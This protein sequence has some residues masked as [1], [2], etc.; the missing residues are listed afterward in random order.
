MNFRLG[1]VVNVYGLLNYDIDFGLSDRELEHYGLSDVEYTHYD[2]EEGDGDL[3][4]GKSHRARLKGITIVQNK[5]KSNKLKK[6]TLFDINRFLDRTGGFVKYHITEV[7]IFLRAIVT[8]WDPV[9]GVCLNDL[10]LEPEYN[11]LFKKYI[12]E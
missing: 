12:R 9:S 3:K 5:G 10:L 4:T 1:F 8:I 6:Q 2:Y 11:L 7:D